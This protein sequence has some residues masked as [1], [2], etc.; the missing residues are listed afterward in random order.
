ME[1]E[2]SRQ[3]DCEDHALWAWRKLVKLGLPAEFVVGQAKWTAD[4]PLEAHAWVTFLQDGRHF[5]LEA[6]GKTNLI[7]PLET[8]AS[9][10]HPWYSIDQNFQTYQYNRYQNPGRQLSPQAILRRLKE[11][12]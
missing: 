7:Y 4:H 2:T 3:G 5:L 1:F 6:T 9:R 12:G 10:Y 8:T 11:S